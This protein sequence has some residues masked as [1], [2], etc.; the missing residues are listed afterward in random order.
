[1]TQARKKRMFFSNKAT[2]LQGDSLGKQLQTRCC[3]HVTKTNQ[4]P[5]SNEIDPKRRETSKTLA[6]EIHLRS[7]TYFQKSTNQVF[8]NWGQQ[9]SIRSWCGIFKEH[10]LPT[11]SSIRSH[12][13]SPQTMFSPQ[14]FTPAEM[15]N[16]SSCLFHSI[17]AICDQNAQLLRDVMMFRC[18]ICKK[19]NV[20][21]WVVNERKRY[22]EIWL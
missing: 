21:I 1:M 9:P 8:L 18:I 19:F 5:V 4:M 13:C 6:K 15:L 17:W 16:P 12:D 2:E 22:W 7:K 11:F 20:N 10:Q 14:K 3:L